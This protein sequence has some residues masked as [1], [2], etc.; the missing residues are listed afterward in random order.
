MKVETKGRRGDEKRNPCVGSY[1][2]RV[3]L[4]NESR[5]YKAEKGSKKK[6]G[7]EKRSS[8]DSIRHI[9]VFFSYITIITI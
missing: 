5:K 3:Q 1:M 8:I 7:R 2:D 4:E 9:F 6:D